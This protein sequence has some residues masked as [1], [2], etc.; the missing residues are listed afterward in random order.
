MTSL[1][2]SV[3]RGPVREAAPVTGCTQAAERKS[4]AL[5]VVR[6]SIFNRKH[7]ARGG[8]RRRRR[9]RRKYSE[10]HRGV[11]PG[12]SATNSGTS[13]D[14]YPCWLDPDQRPALR[15]GDEETRRGERA[16]DNGGRQGE[17]TIR[18][19]KEWR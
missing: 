2:F 12:N 1:T 19:D 11:W 16:G 17:E 8:R 18:G 5:S 4:R 7:G 3:T 9:R 13:T 6:S 15:R 10:S 14:Q